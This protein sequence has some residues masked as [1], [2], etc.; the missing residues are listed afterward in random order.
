MPFK[1]KI[2]KKLAFCLT[3]VF[4]V[5]EI[6]LSLNAK[7]DIFSPIPET[8]KSLSELQIESLP[9]ESFNSTKTSYNTTIPYNLRGNFDESDYFTSSIDDTISEIKNATTELNKINFPTPTEYKKQK[10]LVLKQEDVKKTHETF[11]PKPFANDF[12]SPV[13]ESYVTSQVPNLLPKEENVLESFSNKLLTESIAE[14]DYEEIDLEGKTV[15]KIIINGLETINPETVLSYANTQ[16]GDLFNSDLLQQDLQKIYSSGAFSDNMSIEPTLNDDG[17]V[18]LVLN[19]QENLP[20]RNVEILGNTVFNSKELI[21]FVKPLEGKPQNLNTI[22]VSIKNIT[23]YYHE[24]GYIL[25][26][27]VS[28]DDKKDGSLSFT[29][30]EGVIDKINFA[31]NERTQDYIIKRN[32]LTQAGTVYNEE[33]LK[34]DL[35]KVFS[36]QIFEEVNREINPSQENEGSFDVTIVVKEKSTNSIAF[37]GGIDT[38]LGAFGSISLRED[39]FLGKAQKLSLT[40]ILGSGILLSDASIKNHMNYQA[41]LSFYEPYFLNA[42]NSLMSKLYF[43]EMGSWNVPLA[44]EQRIGLKAG[45]EHKIEGYE[46]LRTSFSVGVENI[47]LK[48]GDF[49][50]ISSLYN[51]HNLDISNRAKQLSDGMF[52]NLTPGVKYSNLDDYEVP[53]EGIVAQAQFNE[54]IG[55]SNFNHTNGRL[56]GAVTKFYP[57]LKKSTFSLTGKAGLKVHGDEMPEVMAYRLGGPYTIR[58]FKMSGVGTGD[59]F[60]MGSAELA[61]PLPFVDKIK[62]D[63]FKKM[64]LTFF[65][66]A[67]KVFDPTISNILY[68]RP[69]HAISAGVGL[70]FYVPGIGP[71]SVDYG[72]PLIN[73]GA[74]G[75]SGGYFTFGT[76]G[77]NN[78]GY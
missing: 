27:V 20:V 76:G 53:R 13:A 21:P 62:W 43:A 72:L 69:E 45:I 46:H 57:V 39:N 8:V 32:M 1:L 48:E 17:T 15:S 64:R 51:K 63:I 70:R 10:I 77:F 60:V 59:S 26:S 18:E 37:G 68:D 12:F 42:D 52:F 49:N 23:D 74:N 34:K 61:T 3:T 9:E 65:I 73:P 33:Y 25:A 40:G 71:I 24:K 11:I 36:T 55:I 14:K 41:E 22:N 67:G 28:V 38:G 47:N 50:S 16:E 58:G 19:L 56:S 6:L 44:V 7:A 54:A 29:I 5:S 35:A 78:Y 2:G 4:A 30:Q 66:D 31:G 75:S